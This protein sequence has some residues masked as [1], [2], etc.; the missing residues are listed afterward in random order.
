MTIYDS[1]RIISITWRC[2]VS[3]SFSSQKHN[4]E[5]YC[6]SILRERPALQLL[7]PLWFHSHR[8]KR[9]ILSTSCENSNS[10]EIRYFLVSKQTV[11]GKFLLDVLEKIFFQTKGM[12]NNSALWKKIYHK[13]E[14]R[15]M[16][17]TKKCHDLPRF[18]S[19]DDST[20]LQNIAHQEER[21]LFPD[22]LIIF[23]FHW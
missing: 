4:K 5:K 14:S 11:K 12:D 7:F 22:N 23:F 13:K 15:K 18:F 20:V 2:K 16:L 9:S 17:K 10:S 3:K 21:I 19:L 1:M 6:S 8:S